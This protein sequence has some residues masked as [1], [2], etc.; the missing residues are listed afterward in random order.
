MSGLKQP[1]P[2]KTWTGYLCP[3]PASLPC[4][5]L[6]SPGTDASRSKQGAQGKKCTTHRMIPKSAS[7]VSLQADRLGAPGSPP[8]TRGTVNGACTPSMH[9]ALKASPAK[10]PPQG[11]RHRTGLRCLPHHSAVPG[12]STPT[13]AHTI[14]LQRACVHRPSRR[15]PPRAGPITLQT[16]PPPRWRGGG[17][18]HPRAAR[19]PRR[20]DGAQGGT[21]GAMDVPSLPG[22]ASG[23]RPHP[24]PGPE[25]DA[26]RAGLPEPSSPPPPGVRGRPLRRE[27]GRAGYLRSPWLGRVRATRGGRALRTGRAG[28]A[29][30]RSVGRRRRVQSPAECR[31]GALAHWARGREGG[32]VSARLR[33]PTRP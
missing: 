24:S 9:T 28:G 6:E 27:A 2:Q 19:D 11:H 32:A 29:A 4:H 5:G 17:Q 23:L 15:P 26:P 22:Q 20:G 18:A 31:R 12:A 10:Y 13:R 33:S 25:A 14:H 1:L 7:R 8:N 16:R 21:G 30:A 3:L